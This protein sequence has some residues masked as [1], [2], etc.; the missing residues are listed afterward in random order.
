MPTRLN[1][2]W[3]G[4]FDRWVWDVCLIVAPEGRFGGGLHPPP[5]HTHSL[6]YALFCSINSLGMQHETHMLQTSVHGYI[7]YIIF[8]LWGVCKSARVFKV[9]ELRETLKTLWDTVYDNSQLFVPSFKCSKWNMLSYSFPCIKKCGVIFFSVCCST[10]VQS[11]DELHAMLTA[12]Q[13]HRWG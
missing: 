13:V 9:A 1:G 7:I 2:F 6:S 4:Q 10:G 11:I 8:V 5:T 12:D 3:V